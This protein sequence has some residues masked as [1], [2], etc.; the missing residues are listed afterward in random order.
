MRVALQAISFSVLLVSQG[1]ANAD[2]LG[3]RENDGIKIVFQSDLRSDFNEPGDRFFVKVD[4]DPA[5]PKDTTLEGRITRIHPANRYRAASMDMIFTSMQLPNGTRYRIDAV[6]TP[7]NDPHLVRGADGRLVAA[8][9]PGDQAG[10]VLGGTVGG[11]IIGGIAHRPV[12]GAFLGAI[13]GSLAGAANRHENA[14]LVVRKGEKMVAVFEQD[15]AVTNAAPSPDMPRIPGWRHRENSGYR[16]SPRAVNPPASP[17]A[18]DIKVDGQ[19]LKFDAA[20]P[21]S[22]D[23]VVMVPVETVADQLNLATTVHDNGSI[24]IDG[25]DSSIQVVQGST[26][27]EGA[28]NNRPLP[29]KVVTRDGVVFVPLSVFA[30][31]GSGQITVNGSAV[32]A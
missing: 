10:Y 14:N 4:K 2:P 32:T 3:I 29:H 26:S 23:G 18:Y 19:P 6:P 28:G 31:I 27:C 15:V 12:T 13:I 5:L 30:R 17:S 9:K 16:F 11:L 21:F 25:P 20:R 1:V 24:T 7:A 8:Y 22:D